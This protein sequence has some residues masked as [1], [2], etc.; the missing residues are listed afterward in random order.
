MDAAEFSVSATITNAT[1][2]LTGPTDAAFT[3]SPDAATRAIVD[4]YDVNNANAT[5]V[6]NNAAI[7]VP[8]ALKNAVD[9]LIQGNSIPENQIPSM[10]CNIKWKSGMDPDYF[11]G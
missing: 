8:A 11:V 6:A 2:T 3:Y 9:A 5:T 10:G 1:V 4:G 7:T